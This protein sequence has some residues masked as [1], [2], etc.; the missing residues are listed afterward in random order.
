MIDVYLSRSNT[1]VSSSLVSQSL[2]DLDLWL[3]ENNK[4][5]EASWSYLI[6]E[7]GEG[8]SCSLFGKLQEVPFQLDEFLIRSNE[9]NILLNKL[10]AIIEFVVDKTKVDWFGAGGDAGHQVDHCFR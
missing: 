9:N 7:L 1:K 10:N 3:K 4:S 8:G 6:P 2:A 5:S